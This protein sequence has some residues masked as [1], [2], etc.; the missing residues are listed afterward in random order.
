MVA[1]SARLLRVSGATTL[2]ASLDMVDTWRASHLAAEAT[3]VKLAAERAALELAR[4]K[5]NAIAFTKLGAETP[6][7]TGLAKGK[8]CAR[9]LGEPIDEQ[10]TRLAALLAARGGKLPD[11][12]KPP[13]GGANAGSHDLNAS[14]L[15]ACKSTGCDPAT[16]ARLKAGRTSSTV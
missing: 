4:R 11:A 3:A 10:N 2:G 8:L 12:I 14:E 5:E 9:L 16:F 15:A 7:T 13:P 6:H 1:A